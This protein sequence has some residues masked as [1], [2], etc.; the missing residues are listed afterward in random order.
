MSDTQ[1]FNLYAYV[2]GSGRLDLTTSYTDLALEG[3]ILYPL[4][5]ICE[6]AM[7]QVANVNH[8]WNDGS[9]KVTSVIVPADIL[10]IEGNAFQACTNLTSVALSGTL[11]KY[12]VLSG[13]TVGA[14]RDCPALTNATLSGA[15]ALPHHIFAGSAPEVVFD[16]VPPTT[17]G[18]GWADDWSLAVGCPRRELAAWRT[19]SRFTALAAI[20][21]VSSKPNY[22]AMVERY[23]KDLLG[24]WDNKWLFRFGKPRGMIIVLQ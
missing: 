5:G 13:G 14:F 7:R 23:G 21:D 12:N 19:D 17:I 4:R 2:K 24:A 16:G 18:T 3:M 8:A 20:E 1:Y 11:E 9:D 10:D 6:R 22:A 15:T